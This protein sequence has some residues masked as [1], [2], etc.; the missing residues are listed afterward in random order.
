MPN[1][2]LGK[3]RLLV[4]LGVGGMGQVWAAHDKEAP[5]ERVVALKTTRQT[6]AEALKVLWDEARLA[7][8][9]QHPNVCPVYELGEEGDITFLVIQWCDGASFHDLLEAAPDHRLDYAIS[10][11]I[12]SHIAAGLHAAHQLTGDDGKLLD[13]V[14]RDVSPQNILISTNGLCTI[15]DFGVA[16]AAGQAHRPTETGEMK[17]KLSYMAPEQVTTKDIDRRVDVFALGCVLY[18]A[19]VGRRPFHGS[20]A[21]ATMYQLLEEDVKKPSEFD[22][23]Y[24]PSLEAILLKAL[25]KNRDDRFQTAEEMHKALEGWLVESKTLVSEDDVATL[26]RTLLGEKILKRNQRIFEVLRSPEDE[27]VPEDSVPAPAEPS[28]GTVAGT[29]DSQTTDRTRPQKKGRWG[30]IVGVA[31]AAVVGAAVFGVDRDRGGSPAPQ[32]SAVQASSGAEK[33]E[34][35]AK[36]QPATPET[37]SFTVATPPTNAK[38]ML[39]DK[40]VGVGKFSMTAEV[41]NKLHDLVVSAEGYKT[42]QQAVSFDKPNALF[43]E[44]E[45]EVAAPEPEPAARAANPGVK[46]QPKQPTSEEPAKPEFNPTLIKRPKKKPRNLDPNP[47][48]KEE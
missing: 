40:A 3:Y 36:P 6:G 27:P 34:P 23:N 38:I 15:T 30:V 29:I 17:G 31:A 41:S 1:R 48:A 4:S 10:V 22:P 11:R 28:D 37:V 32:A 7:S 45:P 47:F 20:D 42:H 13:V 43:V 44:L 26:L 21:L 9:I 25:A 18:Q 35:Q 19:T 8:L 33:P 12:L 16:K 2:I 14:H 39:D 46:R 24:P 5:G